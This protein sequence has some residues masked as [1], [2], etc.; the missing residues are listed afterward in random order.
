M[1]GT[2]LTFA[3]GTVAWLFSV[4]SGP[5]W[6]QIPLSPYRFN[7]TADLGPILSNEASIYVPGSEGFAD[8]TQRWIPW[9]NPSFDVV[10]E[11]GNE[12]DVENTV[13]NPAICPDYR[14]RVVNKKSIDSICE[15]QKDAFSCHIWTTRRY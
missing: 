13:S 12:A 4:L 9:M 1:A 5:N 8:A 6:L 14:G 2:I 11:V 10:V 3:G 15:C 7:I